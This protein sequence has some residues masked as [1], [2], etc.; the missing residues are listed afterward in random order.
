M[1]EGI[2]SSLGLCK[3]MLTKDKASN[4]C[5]DHVLDSISLKVCQGT[6]EHR[7]LKGLLFSEF[8]CIF[9]LLFL[10]E[11]ESVFPQILKMEIE[12]KVVYLHKRTLSCLS[13]SLNA[14]KDKQRYTSEAQQLSQDIERK[15]C[16]TGR[17]LSMQAPVARVHGAEYYSARYQVA[18]KLEGFK[19]QTKKP[20]LRLLIVVYLLHADSRLLNDAVRYSMKDSQLVE[21]SRELLGEALGKECPVKKLQVQQVVQ[22]VYS[23]SKKL[24]CTRKVDAGQAD[25]K[26]KRYCSLKKHMMDDTKS[27]IA[28]AQEYLEEALAHSSPLVAFFVGGHSKLKFENLLQ[29]VAVTLASVRL[30]AKGSQDTFGVLMSKL[31]HS[32]EP[33][34]AQMIVDVEKMCD[35]LEANPQLEES[36]YKWMKTQ[37]WVQA[38]IA[39]LH[40]DN[41][42]VFAIYSFLQKNMKY[43]AE[44][45]Q[46][47]LALLK[48]LMTKYTISKVITLDSTEFFRAN[49]NLDVSTMS[50]I[51]KHILFNLQRCTLLK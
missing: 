45:K 31:I 7:L 14:L 20:E 13:S 21:V 9:G 29:F 1:L 2:L 10:S 25:Q 5:L 15:Y 34:M 39:S 43:Q 36:L 19:D 17:P 6:C 4:G 44:N 48:D 51:L 18:A 33:T 41:H 37:E 42:S 12:E 24:A 8:V 35:P 30:L 16:S 27:S 26:L 32:L 3:R 40:A 23:L 11:L 46:K 50:I 38:S 47:P 49:S 28:T 22:M